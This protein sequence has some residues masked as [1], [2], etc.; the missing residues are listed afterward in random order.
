MKKSIFIIC[1]C[2]L[3]VACATAP[4]TSL[5]GPALLSFHELADEISVSYRDLSDVQPA[6]AVAREA[7]ETP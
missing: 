5:S 3:Q 7:F 4:A 2:F 1:L 6:D